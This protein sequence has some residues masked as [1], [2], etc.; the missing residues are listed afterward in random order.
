MQTINPS[1]TTWIAHRDP[2]SCPL[3]AMAIYQHFLHDKFKLTEKM[4]IDWGINK[5]WR[6]VGVFSCIL[7]SCP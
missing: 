5:S 1:Y 4:E 7:L 6:Q 3:G 2:L